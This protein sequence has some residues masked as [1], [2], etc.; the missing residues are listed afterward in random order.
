MQRPQHLC[1]LSVSRS[2]NRVSTCSATT[3]AGKLLAV[4]LREAAAIMT[5]VLQSQ[6]KQTSGSLAITTF[7]GLSITL[8]DAP[9]RGFISRKVSALLIY[10]AAY[11][12]EHP[13][14]VLSDLLW[15][16][17][18]QDR[19][20]SYLRTALTSLQ[21]QLAPFLQ[22]SRHT[23]A[24]NPAADI[25]LDSKIL[26]DAFDQADNEWRQNGRFSGAVLRS[27][28]TALPLYRG[29]FLEGFNLR[30][31]LNFENW[32]IVEQERLRSRII[33]TL[34]HVGEQALTQADFEAGIDRVSRLLQIDPLHEEAHR[35][36][37]RL[38][39]GSGQRSAALAQYETARRVLREE[40]D[41][42]PEPETTALFTEIKSGSL[43][44]QV[45]TRTPHNLPA[46]RTAFVDRPIDLAMI[47][48]MLVQ[49][50]C[51]LLS[52][53]GLGGIGKTRLAIESARSL[54]D[55]FPDG[56]YF[57]D[58]STI[59]SPAM[60]P[61]VIMGALG[62]VSARETYNEETL[63]GLVIN[64]RML[65]VLDNFEHLL[66]GGD[67]LS[68]LLSR[69]ESLK[70]LVTTRERLNLEEEWLINVNPMRIPA[71]ASDLTHLEDYPAVRLFTQT[72][73]RIQPTFDLM[74]NAV[75]VQQICQLVDGMPLALEL[76]AS[77]LRTL[78]CTAIV[79][80][81]Q[82]NLNILT[83]TARNAHERHR[84]VHAVFETSWRL[85]SPA[86]QGLL[87]RLAA[88]RGS[89]S[90]EAARE[91]T[92]ASLPLIAALVDKSL[93]Q[94]VEGRLRMHKLLWQYA[95]D[96]LS[97]NPDEHAEAIHNHASYYARF[98][99]AHEDWHTRPQTFLQEMTQEIDN[100]SSAW[101]HCLGERD[102][103]N[104][105]PFIRPLYY[106]YFAQ[107]LHEQNHDA[108]QAAMQRLSVDVHSSVL[109]STAARLALLYA[110]TLLQFARYEE[111]DRIHR[112]LLSHFG[113]QPA[114]WEYGLTL[115]NIAHSAYYRG[116]LTEA[117]PYFEQAA[118]A[119]RRS[120]NRFSEAQTLR[121]LATT[122]AVLGEYQRALDLLETAMN[123]ADDLAV[124][125]LR[126]HLLLAMGGSVLNRLGRYQEAHAA[127]TEAL[128][129]AEANGE[130]YAIAI[131]TFNLGRLTAILGDAAQGEAHCLRSIAI[132]AALKHPWGYATAHMHLGA[133]HYLAGDYD[134]ARSALHTSLEHSRAIDSRLM[135]VKAY[136]QLFRTE[137]AQNQDVAARE[138]LRAGL[139]VA[140]ELNVETLKLEMLLAAAEWSA[141]TGDADEA[142]QLAAVLYHHPHAET[143]FR[144]DAARL[145]PAV[146]SQIPP[147]IALD[148]L[149]HAAS[150]RLI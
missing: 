59:I 58:C 146:P 30:D 137:L 72:A 4:I 123:I 17:L 113:S 84:S 133:I 96:R 42:E 71:D 95:N 99:Q 24:I 129:L 112:H 62:P 76:A 109:S 1:Y 33:T 119:F 128:S 48:D 102:E 5:A 104:I 145:V 142:A 111:A 88:F 40:L 140:R 90:I 37:M 43:Q 9:V 2:Y 87:R 16:D 138:A 44:I 149:L 115:L 23:I 13:R 127:I 65:L 63:F 22:V 103:A 107:G 57:V 47:R 75:A 125:W 38:L 89:F 92:G 91:T 3:D 54:L 31:A 46:L 29:T 150:H 55:D 97:A 132:F 94:P 114:S 81:I 122:L 93:L 121:W 117:K 14:E 80:A 110:S 60:L 6:T 10:L 50:P 120:G 141:H 148:D 39:L 56:I 100:I 139:E 12:R 28:D 41:V 77:W 131:A 18:P 15:D 61:L 86:E 32:M 35:L 130:R 116:T 7:G 74:E 118:A 68:R 64:R 83:S 27:L 136:F 73:R 69:T 70:I 11:P 21:R 67:L 66:D 134:Q 98:M 25:W 108:L 126:L 20:L 49:P 79:D 106:Y 26:D 8:N 124:T 144:Q 36:Q 34:Q 101:R 82:Q 147:H 45:R 85:L 53:V 51:R 78:S 143:A 52:L 105:L 19:S 135:Q